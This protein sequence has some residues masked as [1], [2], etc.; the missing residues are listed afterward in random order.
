MGNGTGVVPG[1]TPNDEVAFVQACEQD[2]TE[3]D[4]PDAI[5]DLLESDVVL[6]QGVGDE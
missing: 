6:L 5:F 3:V 2:A 4:G 1:Q